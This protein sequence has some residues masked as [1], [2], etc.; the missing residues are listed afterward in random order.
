V[1]SAFAKIREREQTVKKQNGII[2]RKTASNA[3]QR[4]TKSKK[5]NFASL[6]KSEPC[7]EIFVIFVRFHYAAQ[8]AVHLHELPLFSSPNLISL[9]WS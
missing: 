7:S 6:Q 5:I 4:E 8:L 2:I 1:F 9:T 3:F